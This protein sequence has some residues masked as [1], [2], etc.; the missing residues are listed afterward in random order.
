MKKAMITYSTFLLLLIFSLFEAS[1]ATPPHFP[2]DLIY[3]DKPIDPVCISDPW[4]V[5]Q[6]GIIDLSKCSMAQAHYVFNGYNDVLIHEGYYGW[7]WKNLSDP[8]SPMNG[9]G[10]YQAWDAGDHKYWV[11][12]YY[13]GGGSGHFSAVNLLS[14]KNSHSIRIEAFNVGD[15][16]NGGLDKVIP[17]GNKLLFSLWVTPVGLLGLANDSAEDSKTPDEVY[18]CAICCTATAYYKVDKKRNSEFL[19][20]DLS[21]HEKDNTVE[22]EG[23]YQ[24]CFDKLISSYIA[25]GKTKLDRPQL[26]EFVKRYHAICTK[27][28]TDTNLK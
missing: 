8:E 2:Q 18:G 27:S 7:E 20:V 1:Y 13:D 11:V 22:S 24:A 4:E 6:S 23:R 28:D 19:Y 15:R 16:C 12:T 26:K 5:P 14:R 21:D 17:N 10:Y 9:S 3:H 25:E